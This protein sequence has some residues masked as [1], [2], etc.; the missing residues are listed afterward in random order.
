MHSASNGKTQLRKIREVFGWQ[1][2]YNGRMDVQKLRAWWFHRQGLDG[3]LDGADPRQVLNETG[4]A[5]SVGG[6]GPYLTLF[7]RA[8]VSRQRAD[9]AV[10]NLEIHELP[11]A[12][13][14]TYVVPSDDFALALRAGAKAPDGDLRTALKL[15]VTEQE[16]ETLCAAVLK[17]LESG[18]LDPDEIR[19]ATAGASRSV[20]EGGKKKG[21]TTTLPIALGMLQPQG[22]IRRVPV[23]GRLDQQRYRYT[24]W[25]PSPLAKIEMKEDEVATELA[26]RFFKWAGP[27]TLAEFQTFS[28]LGV[29][30]AR[31]AAEPL[32]L[33]QAYGGSDYLLLPQDRVAFESFTIPTQPKYALLP[34]LD[35]M[36]LHRQ[37]KDIL[38]NSDDASLS[39][40][41]TIDSFGGHSS[42]GIYDRGRLVGLWE[43]DPA[44]ERIAW[45]AFVEKTDALTTAVNRT[46]AFIREQLGDARS[47]SLDSPKS[48]IP[49]IEAIRDFARV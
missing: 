41:P 21:L 43:Y 35:A 23:N 3:R 12:R 18:P 15:G 25:D 33:V 31:K 32:G 1:C 48:R 45:T 4:W 47:F 17:V 26:R 38:T 11:A 2:S 19:Q 29:N 30:A 22:K 36:V 7:S 37:D 46:E 44:A 39:I 34:S 6:S 27:A 14:C 24:L 49:R 5:R 10:A 13:G 8:G 16:I 28:A 42:H 9:E 40:F 20:G